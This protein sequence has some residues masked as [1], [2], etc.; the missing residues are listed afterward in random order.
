MLVNILLCIT[1][2]YP[3]L[4]ETPL[5]SVLLGISH[6]GTAILNWNKIRG[7]AVFQLVIALLSLTTVLLYF[8]R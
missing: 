3:T 5:F 1:G 2:I 4:Y 7:F 6:M 8:L